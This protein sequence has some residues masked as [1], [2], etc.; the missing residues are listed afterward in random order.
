ML[1]KVMQYGVWGL[2]GSLLPAIA[3]IAG[4]RSG[5]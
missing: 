2:F 3:I 1:P 4:A 5:A